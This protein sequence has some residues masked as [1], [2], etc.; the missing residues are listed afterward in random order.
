MNELLLDIH[1]DFKMLRRRQTCEYVTFNKEV[2]D[3][4]HET[5]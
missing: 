3:T 5:F 2:I 1:I 4:I